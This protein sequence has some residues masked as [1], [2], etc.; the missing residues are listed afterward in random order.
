MKRRWIAALLAAVMAFAMLSG[1]GGK[2]APEKSAAPAAAEPGETTVTAETREEARALAQAFYA[3]LLRAEKISMTT[4][5]GGEQASVFTRDG[6]T[7]YMSDGTPEFEYYTFIEDGKKHLL[8]GQEAS[9]NE[10]LY[11]LLAETLQT[12]LDMFVTGVYDAEDADTITYSATQTDKT[13]NGVAV[14]RLVTVFSGEEDGQPASLTVTGRAENGV[15]TDIRYEMASGEEKESAEFR[16][17]YDGVAIELPPYTIVEGFDY[18]T[19]VKG[20]HVDSPYQTLGALI[21]TLDEDETLFYIIEEEEGRV[22]AYGELDGR[23]LQFGAEISAEDADT[24]NNMS[25]FSETYYEDIY[26]ILGKLAVDDCVDYTGCIASRDELDGLTGMTAGD[27][28]NAGFELN[29]WSIW[30]GEATLTFTKDGMEYDVVAAPTEGFDE[31]S[32]FE[33]EDLYGFTVEQVSFSGPE[34]YLLPIR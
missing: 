13:E 4:F 7:M 19:T 16:F 8:E 33:G 6:D 27:M 28:V 2:T 18:G 17:V 23:Q 20:E 26:A 12:T 5:I 32:E 30:G 9:E 25:F 3:E 29:G 31:N 22:Y 21:A 1:C 34:Y 10:F 24:I 11:D 14:S 15:V